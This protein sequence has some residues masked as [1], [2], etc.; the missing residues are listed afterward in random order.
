MDTGAGQGWAGQGWATTAVCS[1]HATAAPLCV[2][3]FVHHT[4][5]HSPC[6][7][8]LAGRF[9]QLAEELVYKHNVI[10][11]ASA[12]ETAMCRQCG[13]HGASTQL[14]ALWLEQTCLSTPRLIRL[15]PTLA[16]DRTHLQQAMPAL[17]CQRWAPPAAPPVP[18]WASVRT[19]APHWRPRGTASGGWVG[20][21]G[22]SA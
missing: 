18:C 22:V 7:H 3:G 10:Y 21:T 2:S 15:R 14:P 20:R 19:S 12:G 16:A 13:R 11:V 17:R 4:T 8:C 5:P 1:S 9:I 6:P